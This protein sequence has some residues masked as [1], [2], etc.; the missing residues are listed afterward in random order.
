MSNANIAAFN[1]DEFRVNTGEVKSLLLPSVDAGMDLSVLLDSIKLPTDFLDNSGETI[2]VE[3]CWRIFNAQYNLVA[4]ESHL[5]SKRPLKR[6]T[7]QFVISNLSHAKNLYEGLLFLANTY[8]VIHGG[9]FNLVKK[10]G[11]TLSYIVDDRD[12]HYAGAPQ[13]LAIEFALLHLHCALC[14]LA[15]TSLKLVRVRTLRKS[16]PD[17]HHHLNL[18]NCKV[19]LESDVY[20]LVYDV[21]Q[22]QCS[23]AENEK[24]DING[25]LLDVYLR[26]VRKSVDEV[27]EQDFI[28]RTKEVLHERS[29]RHLPCDQTSVASALHMS[30][31]TLRRRLQESGESFRKILDQSN[32]ELAINSLHELRS[33]EKAAQRLGYCD[34]RS[35]KRAFIRWHGMSPA[36]YMRA[37]KITT[38]KTP[39]HS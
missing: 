37:H 23:F 15:N 20:E 22:A 1:I 10:R 8:N 36:E 7:T 38:V 39:R 14:V 5:L 6:G 21:S 30:V 12:F 2:G 25:Y 31:A 28:R 27:T 13:Y 11:N 29:M 4:E 9:E 32:A 33:S 3:D 17:F 16:L 18:F 24:M 26:L 34:I 35:F 19:V